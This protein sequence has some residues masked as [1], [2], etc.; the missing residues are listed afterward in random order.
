MGF[1][2]AGTCRFSVLIWFHAVNLVPLP[3]T[4][5]PIWVVLRNVPPPLFTFEGFECNRVCYWGPFI[6]REAKASMKSNGNGEDTAFVR[7]MDKLGNLV[8]GLVFTPSRST[9]KNTKCRCWP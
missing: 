4:A 5:A 6:H 3:I 9:V 1:W 8:L 2:Q 7:V